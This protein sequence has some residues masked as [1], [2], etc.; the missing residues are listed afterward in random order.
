M[1]PVEICIRRG[2]DVATWLDVPPGP[3]ASASHTPIR[4]Y[5]TGIGLEEVLALWCMGDE[6]RLETTVLFPTIIRH[7]LL[8]FDHLATGNLSHTA[9]SLER[10][11]EAPK[12][13]QSSP[14]RFAHV[15]CQK[16][17]QLRF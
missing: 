11:W 8:R 9:A 3:D 5:L 16:V 6:V 14:T 10:R 15:G 2:W 13:T 4:W 7:E 1:T 12:S 17:L